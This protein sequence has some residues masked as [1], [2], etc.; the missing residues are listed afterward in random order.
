VVMPGAAMGAGGEGF[1][2]IALT[3]SE[4]RLEEAAVRLGRLLA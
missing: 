4:A 3:A 2:R 1:L